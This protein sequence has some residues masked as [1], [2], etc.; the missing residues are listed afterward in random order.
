[1]FREKIKMEIGRQELKVKTVAVECGILPT[2]L[3]SFLN[4]Q[5]GL[6]Y[7]YIEKLLDYLHLALVPKK[8]FNFHSDFMEAKEK[9]KDEKSQG[10]G[11][12]EI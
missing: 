7:Q 1:M 3:S 10:E 8:D 12:S 2:S 6:K 4:G 9:A 5:R 11:S